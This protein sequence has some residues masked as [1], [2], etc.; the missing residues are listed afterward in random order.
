[1]FDRLM[2]AMRLKKENKPKE[3]NGWLR[4]RNPTYTVSDE[5]ESPVWDFT[6]ASA[7][8]AHD[9]SGN[10]GEFGGAGASSGWDSGSSDSSSSSDC[11]SSDSG[12]SSSGC[13]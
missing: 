3:S 2:K 11:S 5:V 13:D 4:G 7:S 12:S 1:M 8:T 10:G 9:F 6:Q